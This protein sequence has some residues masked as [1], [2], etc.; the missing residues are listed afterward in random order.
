MSLEITLS[1]RRVRATWLPLLVVFPTHT[2]STSSH[3][4]W[5]A[6]KQ[7]CKAGMQLFALQSCILKFKQPETT[8]GDILKLYVFILNAELHC[9]L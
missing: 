8:E 5:A 4:Q 9:I 6:E 3:V 7:N 2:Y 1:L